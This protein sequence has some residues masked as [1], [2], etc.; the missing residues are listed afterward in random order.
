[1]DERR[2]RI[3]DDLRGVIEGELLFEPVERAPYAHDASLYEIDPVGVIVPRTEHD[4]VMAL[5]YAV[6]N[7][8]PVHARGAGTSLA[9]ETLG[10]G[11]VIDFSRYFR[12]IV[13]LEH[14][15]VVVQA[16][17]V[18]DVLN[19][20]L[21]PLG[22]RLAS[23]PKGSEVRTI[24]GMIGLDATGPRSLRYGSIGD[25]IEEL[26][27]IY[28]NGEI[29]EVGAERWPAFDDEP[30]E[31]KDVVVR[32]LGALVRRSGET[33]ARKGPR[34]V[35]NR[36]GYALKRAATSEGI[37]LGRLL[38][39]SEGTLALVTEATLRT[40]PIPPA[41]GVAVL[42]FG[43]L[44]DAAESAIDCLDASPSVCDV[45]DWRSIRL[46]R[47]AV[48]ALRE[49]IAEEAEAVLIV[50]FEGQDPDEVASHV[51]ALGRVLV[52]TGRLVAAPAEV[53]RRVDCDRL[54]G[55]RRI[56]EPLLM[57][58]RGR[59]RPV[60][61]IEDVA[62]PP[63]TLAEFVQRLQRILKAYEVSWTLDGHAAQGHLHTR[64]FLDLADPRDVAKL[65]PM[66]TQVY[67]AAL[68]LGGT[69][70]GEH[71]CGL[72]R[73]QFLRRQ[74]G[75]LVQVFREVKDAFDPLNVL[76]PGKVIGDDPHLMTRDLRPWPPIE[77]PTAI[78]ASVPLPSPPS[79]EGGEDTGEERDSARAPVL[80]P[81]LRWTEHGR[82]PV[83]TAAAC[84]GC[85]LC[86]S[87]EPTLRMC[88]TFRGLGSEA[89]APRAKAN[90]IRQLVTGAIDPK[91][92]GSEEF[93]ANADLCVHCNL[94]SKECPSGVDVSSLMLE[95]KA[96]F[97]ENHGLPPRAWMLSRV[98]LWSR[99]ASRLPILY[100]AAMTSRT[101][102]WL[103]ERLL[104][105][106]RL[107]SLPR[108]HRA[109]FVRRVARRGMTKP[110]PHAPGP[111]VAFFVD[112][113]ANYFDQELAETV[114]A[115]LHQAGVN[116]YVP[117][118]QRGSG[119]PALVAGDVDHARDL[120]LLNL[121]ALGNA[122][123]DGYTIVC[124]EPT[125]TLMI[126]HEYLKLT[127]DLDAALVAANTM[128]LGQY[129]GGL[130]ARGQLPRP[131]HPIRA[132]VGYHQPCHLRALEVGTPGLDLIREIPELEVEFID[133]GCS[134]MAGTYGLIRENFR[135]SLRAG[136]GLLN[137]LRVDDIDIGSTECGACRMQ[138]EQ[139][140]T[141]RTLH[142]IKLLSL[143]YG[144]NPVLL[145][146]IKEPKPRRVLS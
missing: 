136:R 109:P 76:N 30:R 118:G 54:V 135:T 58:M 5:R 93:K 44:A 2:A 12:R 56:V 114:V 106:S 42:P 91:L 62:V 96:A 87:R 46:V 124:S 15:S 125:A 126:R 86:R 128:D 70:S 107:R 139:G 13:A 36:A 55:L 127:D 26:R 116:V 39:G 117:R 47:D 22:R 113:F 51:Q 72:L 138:M 63:E 137:R 85:G 11:L 105:L 100:N 52:Q 48:P 142:P 35:R 110:R 98:E 8:L 57:R 112:V 33:I 60:P 95:A 134:G 133:R 43:R 4:V 14:E 50:E 24:G 64:P 41:Q 6:E 10:S 88:P 144:L 119:M 34:A 83:E 66:A 81:I 29:N 99:L 61:L 102:R 131:E 38:A 140:V 68:E 129:L 101:A 73:T 21:A 92:W 25:Q 49:W 67:E 122:V 143:G 45:Y 77:L 1:V 53:F 104:G 3:H 79:R 75:E 108:A 20:Q 115:V 80:V 65:E 130:R 121:R 146:H 97:V 18:L 17:V 123:R 40:V 132:R 74:Y 23:D 84:N 7:A 27:I 9:G 82:G 145:R 31:F 69:V 28:A 32:K 59:S 103:L 78:E 89:A 141:K 111:R 94:C 120:A 19:A 16:G 37:H 71:G 90:L